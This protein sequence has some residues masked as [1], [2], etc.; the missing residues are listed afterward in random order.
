VV[1]DEGSAQAKKILES[2]SS[3][4]DLFSQP[5]TSDEDSQAVLLT[6]MRMAHTEPERYST[7]VE[8]PS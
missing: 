5:I 2:L 8:K 1:E 4:Q 3:P 7:Q 6:H